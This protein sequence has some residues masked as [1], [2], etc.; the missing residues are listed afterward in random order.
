MTLI[1]L[2]SLLKSFCELKLL[3]LLVGL[4]WIGIFGYIL[5]IRS[6]L[7]AFISIEFILLG[8]NL[9]FI[10][11]AQIKES[12]LGYEMVLWSISTGAAE[13]A[14]G[15]ALLVLLENRR[16]TISIIHHRGLKG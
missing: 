1:T 12:N 10:D 8:T 16:N 6:Y 15:L 14:I 7:Q 3:G 5:T 13:V 4:I 11:A 9:L 2:S